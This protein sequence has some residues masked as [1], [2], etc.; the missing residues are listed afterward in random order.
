MQQPI[1][2]TRFLCWSLEITTT[3]FIN[4]SSPCVDALES[5]FTAMSCPS[6]NF[7]CNKKQISNS[8]FNTYITS[9]RSRGTGIITLYTG[10]KPPC[11]SLLAS[12]KLFVAVESLLK[13]ISSSSSSLT[14]FTPSPGTLGS[15]NFPLLKDNI[16]SIFPFFADSEHGCESFLENN[17]KHILA[18]LTI[19]T[20]ADYLFVW[21][22]TSLRSKCRGQWQLSL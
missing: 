11:P 16:S 17:L 9:Q 22:S 4:S 7:P 3:S 15:E 10:P 2:L 6:A 18:R 14:W 21:Q 5:L 19:C 20:L 13:S 8:L 12:W 1:S